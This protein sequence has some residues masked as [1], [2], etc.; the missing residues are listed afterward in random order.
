ME[1]VRGMSIK[2]ADDLLLHNAAAADDGLNKN[3]GGRIRIAG[4]RLKIA[5]EEL[6][7]RLHQI[8]AS[9]EDHEIAQLRRRRRLPFSVRAQLLPVFMEVGMVRT[10]SRGDKKKMKVVEWAVDSLSAIASTFPSSLV[11][12]IYHAKLL[13][14]LGEY[15]AAEREC[16]R[17]LCIEEPVD[18]KLHDIPLGSSSGEDYSA[19]V[20][21]AKNEIYGI[22][23]DQE[24]LLNVKVE[25]LVEYYRGSNQPA[26]DTISG[27][28]IQLKRLNSWSLWI[29]PFSDSDCNGCWASKP[30]DLI[31]QFLL[32]HFQGVSKNLKSVVDPKLNFH[33]KTYGDGYSPFDAEPSS[34]QEMRTKKC[35]EAA[36]ILKSLEKELKTFPKRKSGAKVH[37]ALDSLQRLWIKLLEASHIDYREAILPLMSSFKWVWNR[38]FFLEI[39][40]C[41]AKDNDTSRQSYHMADISDAVFLDCLGLYVENDNM[42]HQIG[43]EGEL[44]DLK[45]LCPDVMSE[46]D[47]E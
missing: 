43:G 47:E 22:K 4:G 10:L 32:M 23:D 14:V 1:F 5:G 30:Q 17:A 9:K 18:P 2:A 40:D 13:A 29:C 41:F 20:L 8:N 44:E 11:I 16:N 38:V 7:Q 39:T 34:V 19:R 46:I 6:R 12:A 42:D 27:A 37:K 26:V 31:Q 33:V 3:K 15:E 28:V 21:A 36:V 25:T 35:R 24:N 45:T